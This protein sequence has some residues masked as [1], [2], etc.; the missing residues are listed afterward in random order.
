MNVAKTYVTLTTGTEGISLDD[1][2]ADFYKC[3]QANTGGLDT[4]VKFRHMVH[5]IFVLCTEWKHKQ[6]QQCFIK[7][8]IILL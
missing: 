1:S 3:E 5:A 6:D 4:I 8:L 7:D 2:K